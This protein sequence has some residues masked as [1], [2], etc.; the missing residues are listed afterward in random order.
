VFGIAVAMGWPDPDLVVGKLLKIWRWFDQQTID[1]NAPSVTLALLDNVCG[2]TGFAKAMCDVGWLIESVGGVSLPNFDWHNGKTAKA[3]CLTAKRVASHKSNAKGNAETNSDSV[4]EALPREEK[5]REE[6]KED[7]K[8]SAVAPKSSAMAYLLEHGVAEQ[9][10]LDWLKL[11]T[12]KKA[13]ATQ[14][15][16]DIVR[17]EAEIAGLSLEGALQICCTRGWQGFKASWV[18]ESRS[19]ATTGAPAGAQQLG[20]AGQAT[21]RAVEELLREQGHD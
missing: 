13:P 8:H 19:G 20:R 2:V 18:T 14:T 21:A 4:T 1:G 12:A 10:A 6:K 11:R 17:R 15:A 16:L 3:R 7:K 5:R 9:T